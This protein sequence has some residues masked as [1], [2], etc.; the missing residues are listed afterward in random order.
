MKYY[1]NLLL[2]S[3]FLLA[4]VMIIGRGAMLYA[5]A[6]Q[7]NNFDAEKSVVASVSFSLKEDAARGEAISP[8]IYGQFIEH[9]GRCIYGGIWAEMLED[10]KF[11]YSVGT[12]DSPWTC[13]NKEGLQMITEEPFVGNWTPCLKRTFIAQDDLVLQKNREYQGYLWAKAEGE[14]VLEVKI[15]ETKTG[16]VISQNL[17]KISTVYAKYDFSFTSDADTSVTLKIKS[18]ESTEAKLFVG[19]VSLMPADNI[20]GMRADTLALLRE[21]NSPIYR[22]PGGNFVSGYNWKDGVGSRDRR[23][24]RKNPAWK[25]VEHNDFGLDEFMI[26]CRF[27]ETEPYIAVN[28]GNGSVESAVQLL[29]YVNGL[30]DTPMGKLRV[31]NAAKFGVDAK[32]PYAVKWWG[33]G[34]EMYGY[35][36]IGNIPV[37]EYVKRHIEF[38]AAFRKK[39]P[40]LILVGVGNVGKWDDVFIP[41]AFAHMDVISEHFYMKGHPKKKDDTVEH[42]QKPVK[43]IRYIAAAHREYAKKFLNVY[44]GEKLQV[45]MDE[46]NY[47]Y[48]PYVFGELGTRYFMKDALGIAAGL[49]EYFR[50]SDVYIMAN[51]AQAV[52]VIGAIKTSETD[53][54]MESTGEVLKLYRRHFASIPLKTTVTAPI[55]LDVQAAISEDEKTITVGIVNPHL[56]KV[57]LAL[58]TD[59]K[60]PENVKVF[61]VA[62]PDNNP[63]SYNDP[64][65]RA[66][67]I[68]SET[69]KTLKEQ[70]L[71]VGPLTV[72]ILK[73]EKK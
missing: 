39:D 13:G 2:K 58:E 10:R 61:T 40:S 66:Q 52:N 23:P 60:L 48:G 53:A 7:K 64:G 56:H 55:S 71:T 1:E 38:A 57:T 15:T 36:Q 20:H 31:E 6:E 68:S 54:C 47:W 3:L 62:N 43:I 44:K 41:G 30:P 18:P 34:N 50:N 12:P 63:V 19:T 16:R 51:Y 5:E 8:L 59:E 29:E 46:W 22:W 14:V 26:F 25:G 17:F 11:F 72:T 42:Y 65:K 27:L 73:F 70:T 37:K 45:A 24:P 9:L 69:M 4:G 32:K 67:I 28:T 49:H 21:L 33:L 35:W